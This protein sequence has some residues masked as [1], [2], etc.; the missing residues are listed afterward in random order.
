MAAS[1]NGASATPGRPRTGA[2][3]RFALGGRGDGAATR[4]VS[5]PPCV[6][7]RKRQSSSRKVATEKP[8]TM[9]IQENSACQLIVAL[10]TCCRGGSW[11]VMSAPLPEN[12][13]RISLRLHEAAPPHRAT[14]VSN[15]S[16]AAPRRVY[17]ARLGAFT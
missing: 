4:C 13:L 14:V 17:S 7:R 2:A 8:T 9:A 6:S 1:A 16:G 3:G 5:D 15:E 10:D 12:G 11:S